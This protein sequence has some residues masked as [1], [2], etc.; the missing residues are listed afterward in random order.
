M[1]K[2]EHTSISPSIQTMSL[3]LLSGLW[4]LTENTECTYYCSSS[5][6]LFCLLGISQDVYAQT[7]LFQYH[8][9]ALSVLG[10][11]CLVCHTAVLSRADSCD[12]RCRGF[13]L[14]NRQLGQI[15]CFTDK[16]TALGETENGN[17]KKSKVF[18]PETLYTGKTFGPV[19]VREREKEKKIIIMLKKMILISSKKH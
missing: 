4:Y 11:L 3:L 12:V 17:K 7:N 16:N 10:V 5:S 13:G 1:G 19:K 18:N 14:G 2:D 15:K 8:C 6:I 9:A